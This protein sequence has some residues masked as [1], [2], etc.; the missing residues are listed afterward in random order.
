MSDNKG[1]KGMN[2]PKEK[3]PLSMLYFDEHVYNDGYI[4]ANCEWPDRLNK[5]CYYISKERTGCMYYPK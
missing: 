4:F 3:A 1:H 5:D 2:V